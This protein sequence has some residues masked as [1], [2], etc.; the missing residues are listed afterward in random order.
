LP[1]SLNL[2]QQGLSSSLQSANQTVEQHLKS[3]VKWHNHPHY[4]LLFDPQTA[5][6]LVAVLPENKALNCLQKLHQLGYHAATIIGKVSA[7]T[8]GVIYLADSKNQGLFNHEGE[9]PL[10]S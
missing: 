10:T 3:Q 5:G 4:P 9:L 2:F 6:G 7:D 1:G 8:Q